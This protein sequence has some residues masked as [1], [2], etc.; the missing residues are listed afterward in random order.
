MSA[1]QN[2]NV[3]VETD[4]F[5]KLTAGERRRFDAAVQRL[6]EFVGLPAVTVP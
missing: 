2:K 4:F 5:G 3:V 6:G 1:S